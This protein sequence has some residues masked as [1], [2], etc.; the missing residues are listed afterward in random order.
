M[1]LISNRNTQPHIEQSMRYLPIVTGLH[2]L[3]PREGCPLDEAVKM[4]GVSALWIEYVYSYT[5]C[6]A[7]RYSVA[8]IEDGFPTRIDLHSVPYVP[9]PQSLY[10]K[11]CLDNS[12]TLK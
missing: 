3:T 4:Y 11:T 8:L 1:V 12:L 7:F 10:P 2:N 9:C 6:A 5:C